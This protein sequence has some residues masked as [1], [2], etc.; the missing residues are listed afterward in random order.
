M[1]YF[2]LKALLSGILVAAASELA[3]RSPAFGALIVSLP[4]VALL[5]LVWLWRD[6][7]DSERVAALAQSTFWFVLP[8]LPMFLV[9]PALLRLGA[10]F[11]PVLVGACLMTVALYSAMVWMLA[12]SGIT[13]G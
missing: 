13:L 11:W 4:L 2:V 3:R 5:S 10:P 7:G 1:T 12:R 6:T 9:V 8:S